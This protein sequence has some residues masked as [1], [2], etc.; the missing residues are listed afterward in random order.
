MTVR[1]AVRA[2]TYS[3]VRRPAL[4]VAGALLAAANLAGL[5]AAGFTLAATGPYRPLGF[6]WFLLV[7]AAVTLLLAPAVLPGL[8][9][10]ARRDGDESLASD[11]ARLAAEARG[12]YVRLFG[13]L[14]GARVA[15]IG[16]ALLVAPLLAG[17]LLVL[18]TVVTVPFY[19]LGVLQ[20]PD[21]DLFV[22]LAVVGLPTGAWAVGTLPVAFADVL[23]LDGESPRA[24][25]L[26]SLRLARDRPRAVVGYALLRWGLVLTPLLVLL[27]IERPVG[28]FEGM[29]LVPFVGLVLAVATVPSALGAAFHVTFYDRSLRPP[30]APVVT[31]ARLRDAV[32]WP[33]VTPGRRTLLVGLLV[34]G[35]VA[36]AGA[37][38]VADLRPNAEPGAPPAIESSTPEDLYPR[39]VERTRGVS[40]SIEYVAT[41]RNASTGARRGGFVTNLMVDYPDRQIG[42]E[43]RLVMEGE[44][45]SGRT[46]YLGDGLVAETGELYYV[47]DTPWPLGGASRW[48]DGL[49][50]ASPA[51]WE[52]ARDDAHAKLPA[53]DTAWRVQERGDGFVVLAASEPGV[54]LR[55][56]RHNVPTPD[57]GVVRNG[58]YVRVRIDTES[59]RITRLAFRARFDVYESSDNRTVTRRID[60]RV[61]VTWRYDDT[62]VRRP[63]DLGFRPWGAVWDLLYY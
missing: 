12:N 52:F 27:A 54:A 11:F 56:F 62:D 43:M 10:V 49:A 4:L 25:W 48:R 3:V 1:S 16:L 33:P 63:D 26:A 34:V 17:L 47:L 31:S 44:Q 30:D 13:T 32:G 8:Y 57:R 37:V 21:P 9:A 38:R 53:G 15:G 24:A 5:F 39:A 19:A 28:S 50:R 60:N 14:L 20:A 18:A 51:Y 59:D 55:A 42:A 22:F 23:A 6:V 7:H 41:Y 46:V 35:L 2:A 36:S 29:S 40:R 61:T 45:R 58:S